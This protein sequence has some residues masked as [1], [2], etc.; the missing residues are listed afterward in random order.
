VNPS[1]LIFA[2]ALPI[3]LFVGYAAT[4]LLLPTPLSR[5][6]G[7]PLA[8]G[9]GAGICSLVFFTF[10]RP[11]FTIEFALLI[12]LAFVLYRRKR[13]SDLVPRVPS[14]SVVAILLYGSVGLLLGVFALRVDRMPHGDWDGWAIWNSHARFLY[15]DGPNWKNDLQ[16]TFHGDYPL[17]TPSNTARL[18]R[19]AGQEIPEAGSVLAIMLALSSVGMLVATLSLLRDSSLA[20]LFG[21]ILLS[22]P[23][24]LDLSTSQYADVPLSFFILATIAL[25]CL[26]FEYKTRSSGILL[27]AGFCAGCA[28]WTKNEGILF[29]L[30]VCVALV[31]FTATRA[32]KM[33]RRLLPFLAGLSI[34]LATLIIFKSTVPVRNDLIENQTREAAIHRMT[35]PSRYTFT[36]GY[37]LKTFWTFGAWSLT[38]L[39]P[40]AAFAI[41][42][43]IDGR[44]R[45][46]RGWLIGTLTVGSVLLGYFFVYINTPIELK[47]H[48]GSSLDRL[49]IHLWPSFLL[50]LGLSLKGSLSRHDKSLEIAD[51]SYRVREA[52]DVDGSFQD[53]TAAVGPRPGT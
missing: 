30:A 14:N 12:I 33:W 7:L 43:K 37:F 10:R 42:K 45:H 9:V 26:H 49:M 53:T 11:M 47:T 40:L 34:P 22:T 1:F 38:P 24:Y 31:L 6:F 21:L 23:A 4:V 44:I 29:V 17:L 27:L 19:Y 48:L 8:P 39:A 20:N 18:W 36:L 25:I 50:L 16:Y 32:K 46:N 51:Y 41:L 13:F 15:R 2:V 3:L 35:D 5:R 52:D 28:A